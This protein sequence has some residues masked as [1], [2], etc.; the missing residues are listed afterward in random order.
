MTQAQ[1][2]VDGCPNCELILE[3]KGSTERVLEC[4]TGTFDGAIAIVQPDESWVAK[5]QRLERCVP[6]LYAA[7]TTGQL[8]PDDEEKL[9]ERGY[10]IRGK[11]ED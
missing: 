2:K 4:T 6:G 1:F 10:I 11:D 5:F 8:I 7:R 9:E 3:M